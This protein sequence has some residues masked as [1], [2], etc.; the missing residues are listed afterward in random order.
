V[1]PPEVTGGY[2]LKIDRL[3]QGEGGFSAGGAAMVFVEPKEAAISLPQR[4][5]QEQYLQTFFNDFNRALHRPTWKDPLLGYRA[6]IDVDSWVDFHVLE[7][8]SGNVDTLV[9]S[10]YFHKP[11]NGKIVFGPHWDFDRA[12][13]STDGRDDNPRQWNTGRFFDA[14]WWARLFRDP[15]FWQQWVDRW[16]ELRGSHF[17][18]T[19]INA[20]IDRLSGELREA[21]PREVARWGLHPR[22]G[23]YQTEIDLMKS[24]L[25]NRTD[26]IDQQLVQPPRFSRAGGPVAPGVS[27][28]L[29]G[30]TNAT[31]YYTVDG[32]DPRLSQGG[33]SSNSV[34]YV[35]PFSLTN[36]ARVI[37]RAHDPTQHQMGGPPDS[38]PWSAPAKEDFLVAPR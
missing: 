31:I 2:L 9:L 35:A 34:I 8:L 14:P 16:E 11:R 38:T 18:T 21:Q 15:D 7:V 32:S 33:I 23:S 37:A 3:G 5:P 12:L 1:K 17:S 26:F 30:P 27:L 25:S 36:N 13:G 6:Y 22:G 24:W 28:A 10:T 20:L 19:N 4:A 29:T